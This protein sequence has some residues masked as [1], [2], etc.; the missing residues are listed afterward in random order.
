MK[1]YQFNNLIAV[2]LLLIVFSCVG[3]KAG[4]TH[5]L[6]QVVET[7]DA[8]GAVTERTTLDFSSGISAWNTKVDL[9]Q[10]QFN[11]SLGDGSIWSSSGEADGVKSTPETRAFETI[12]RSFA[13]YRGMQ[14]ANGN[15]SGMSPLEQAI[16]AR[17]FAGEP[18]P[19]EPDPEPDIDAFTPDERD[20]LRS[21]LEERRSEVS[22]EP[23]PLE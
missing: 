11:E 16:L 19:N 7:L 17:I 21:F 4:R 20:A 8:T 14:A 9:S 15:Q 22:P 23:D 10:I 18:R 6:N 12:E 13:I 5:S 1:R 3:C 2:F